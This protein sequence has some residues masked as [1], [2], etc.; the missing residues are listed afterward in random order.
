MQ[1]YKLIPLQNGGQAIVDVEDH[2]ALSKERWFRDTGGYAS[3]QGWERDEDGK[4]RHWTIWLHRVVNKTPEG[5]FTDHKNGNKLDNRKGNLRTCDKAQNSANRP[6]SKRSQLSSNLK[7]VS[8]HRSTGL[9]RARLQFAGKTQ[10][11][12][13]KTAEQ[14]GLDYNR[15]AQEQ[16]GEFS[17][18][19]EVPR[20]T[21][22]T[23]H[24]PTT[25]QYRGVSWWKGEQRWIAAIGHGKTRA[26][27]GRFRDERE[28][29]LAWNEAAKLRYGERATLNQL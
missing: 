12:Y 21:Q 3:R 9:W 7:G 18:S 17:Q 27:V 20:G 22:P 24:K 23:E 14:A 1:N 2:E 6:K 5:M 8:F 10:T 16:F 26:I 19:N 13:H 11:T 4:L 25:S 15:M 28:A 29:A